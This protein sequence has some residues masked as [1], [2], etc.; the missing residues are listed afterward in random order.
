LFVGYNPPQQKN[1]R[2]KTVNS[3]IHTFVVAAAFAFNGPTSRNKIKAA[4]KTNIQ[5]IMCS[6]LHSC[7]RLV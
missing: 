5:L 6:T 7:K 2:E 3:L 1:T 4:A